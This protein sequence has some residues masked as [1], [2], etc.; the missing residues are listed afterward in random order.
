MPARAEMKPGAESSPP[1]PR[2]PLQDYA[3]AEIAERLVGLHFFYPVSRLPGRESS[4]MTHRPAAS[5]A[6]AC[7][8]GAIRPGCTAVK[9]QLAGF[10]RQ[11]RA[12]L[13]TMLERL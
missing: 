11:P 8:R 13:L 7:L 6:G 1:P 10:S 3:L 5:G 12:D 9:E 4:V 2:H